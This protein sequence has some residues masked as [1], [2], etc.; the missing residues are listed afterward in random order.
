MLKLA[1]QGTSAL[2]M[3][4]GCG[5]KQQVSVYVTANGCVLLGAG[6]QQRLGVRS[7]HSAPLL[8]SVIPTTSHG[9]SGHATTRDTQKR[10]FESL[11][12]GSWFLGTDVCPLLPGQRQQHLNCV[13]ETT[14]FDYFA[15]LKTLVSV[16]C[17]ARSGRT[18]VQFC[19]VSWPELILRCRFNKKTYIRC[20]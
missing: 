19:P 17:P 16:C 18:V 4:P 13:L 1:V 6:V 12:P 11:G 10:S 3:L 14:T 15:M 9:G 2:S 20:H 5:Q 7:D 8:S